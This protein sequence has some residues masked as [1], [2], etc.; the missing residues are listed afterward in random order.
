MKFIV[1]QCQ[2]EGFNNRVRYHFKYYAIGDRS[3]TTPR[4]ISG[5]HRGLLVVSN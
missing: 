3:I 4:D 5:H 2:R 1:Y